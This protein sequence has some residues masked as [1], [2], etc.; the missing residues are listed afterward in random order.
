MALCKKTDEYEDDLETLHLAALHTL[1]SDKK[2]TAS[3]SSLSNVLHQS[4]HS[5]ISTVKWKLVK[6]LN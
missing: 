3:S 2:A 5:H 1:G 6:K 4:Q